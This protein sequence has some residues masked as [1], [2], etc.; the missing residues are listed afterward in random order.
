MILEM[1][2]ERQLAE[3][4]TELCSAFGWEIPLGGNECGHL[5][6]GISKFLAAYSKIQEEIKKLRMKL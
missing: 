2:L 3:N 6:E 4:F 1:S 5:T